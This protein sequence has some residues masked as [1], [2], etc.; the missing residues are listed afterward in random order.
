M[1][2]MWRA[3]W[4]H[5]SS[6]WLP[7]IFSI[8]EDVGGWQ[9]CHLSQIIWILIWISNLYTTCKFFP[10]SLDCE[11]ICIYY[12]GLSEEHASSLWVNSPEWV[13]KQWV[14]PAR[15]SSLWHFNLRV[16]VYSDY[17][18]F[19]LWFSREKTTHCFAVSWIQQAFL[20]INII[21]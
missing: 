3:L 9:P 19:L 4:R 13:R 6:S 8:F 11:T 14:A 1:T 12:V 7:I 5:L 17:M 15:E 20:P 18:H 16:H 21:S 10:W 2:S